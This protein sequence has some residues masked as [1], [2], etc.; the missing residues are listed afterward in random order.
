MFLSARC[1]AALEH[2]ALLYSN[3]EF[4]SDTVGTRAHNTCD[5]TRDYKDRQHAEKNIFVAKLPQIRFSHPPYRTPFRQLAPLHCRFAGLTYRFIPPPSDNNAVLPCCK[6]FSNLCK[7]TLLYHR[8]IPW[9]DRNW[10]PRVR[11][12][13]RQKS[14][15]ELRWQDDG[16]L[17][18][19]FGRTDQI[20]G[21]CPAV[22]L[23]T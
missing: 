13:L 7:E 11:A 15:A 8:L 9:I 12:K 17:K 10:P 1:R 4:H 23:A 19:R 6:T 21:T 5:I 14:T 2:A 22:I 16:R 3:P 18:F 20:S